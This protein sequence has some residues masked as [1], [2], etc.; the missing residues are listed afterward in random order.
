MPTGL[1]WFKGKLYASAWSVAGLFLG[2][3]GA[4]QIVSVSD[5]AFS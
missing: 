2:I 5:S 1:L 3:E 4:G